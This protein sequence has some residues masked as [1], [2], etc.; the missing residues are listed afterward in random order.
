MIGSTISHYKILEKLGEGG[1]GVVYKAQDTKLD[2]TVA[3]KFL[4]PEFTRD[5]DAKRRFIR[6][7]QAASALDHPNIAVVHEIDESDDGRSF[8]CM[9]YYEG[10]TLK[11]RIESGSHSVSEVNHIALQIVEGL[12]RAHEAG[13]VHCDIKPANIIV[14]ERGEVKIVDFGIAKLVSQTRVAGAVSIGGTAA[15]MSPEQAQGLEVDQRSDLFSLGIVLYEM[16]TGKRPFQGEHEPAVLYAITNVDPPAP[17]TLQPKIPIEL[18]QVILRLLE[19]DRAK[20]YQSAATVKRTLLDYGQQ[21]APHIS[22]KRWQVVIGGTILLGALLWMLVPGDFWMTEPV[23]AKHWRIGILPFRDL[24]MKPETKEWPILVQMMLVNEL[25][26]VEEIGVVEPLS[27]NNLIQSAF[28]G[29]Q[30]ERDEQLFRLIRTTDVSFI[31][32]GT[33]SEKED[34][35]VLQAA[36]KNPTT[37]ELLLS[38]P[39]SFRAE[40]EFPSLIRSLSEEILNYFQVRVLSSNQ[41]KDL[42]PWIANKAQNMGAVKEFLQASQ[43]VFSGMRGTEPY[44]RRAIE[45]DSTFISPRVWL[46]SGIVQRGRIDEAKK[47]YEELEKLRPSANPFEQAMITWSGAYISND[48]SLQLRSAKLALKYSPN[49]NILLYEVASTQYLLK[50]YENAVESLRPVIDMQWN[51]SPAYYLLAICYTQLGQH[52]QA[53]QLLEQ[54]LT[55]KPVYHDIYFHLS[56]YALAENDTT[57]AREYEKLYLQ[58]AREYGLPLGQH[59]EMLASNNAVHKKYG[60]AVHYYRAAI[61]L[62]PE[63]AH[64]HDGL[65]EVLYQKKSVAEAQ[66]LFQRTLQLDSGRSNAHFRLG[67]INEQQN[68]M[69][70]ALFHYRN[71]LLLDSLSQQ[72]DSVRQRIQRLIH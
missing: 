5:A 55:V 7:A 43:I 24:V 9:A 29:I 25:V 13:I 47:Q 6:E 34:A 27:M 63:N 59:Y 12:Q 32:D 37:R 51:Y 41:D 28:G 23:E 36:I 35:F 46:I 19:K 38:L 71:Y 50:E 48:T 26:G 61:A 39:V 17:S 54:S 8:I 60:E 31:I 65:G 44:L 67:E 20:R 1:M 16:V 18:E 11:K 22:V 30:V 66:E 10:Q 45:L 64:L 33:I 72:A 15:Y 53:K 42:R 21:A 62:Q 57:K 3:L 4:P 58:R 70:N 68:K 40:A 52:Q 2:R 49:N 69:V 56:T 14:T